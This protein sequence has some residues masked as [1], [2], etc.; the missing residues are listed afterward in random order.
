MMFKAMY[1]M[2]SC[3]KAL[4]LNFGVNKNLYKF[5]IQSQPTM[6]WLVLLTEQCLNFN[7]QFKRK[8]FNDLTFILVIKSFFMLKGPKITEMYW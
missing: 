3:N 6:G 2:L 1:Y 8:P 5:I 7:R 4:I